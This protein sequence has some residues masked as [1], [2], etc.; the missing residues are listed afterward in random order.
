MRASITAEKKFSVLD[1][2]GGTPLLRLSR[3]LK[4]ISPR[5]EIYAKAERF[6][7]GLLTG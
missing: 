5:L 3:I 7:P 2:I 1:H 6:N 4:E